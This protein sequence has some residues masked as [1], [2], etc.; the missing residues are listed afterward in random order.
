MLVFSNEEATAL[1]INYI[2]SNCTKNNNK[3][4]NI[5]LQ[6][7]SEKV[8]WSLVL[9]AVWCEDDST[10]YVKP[11]GEKVRLLYGDPVSTHAG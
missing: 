7:L 2:F 4:T 5:R 11:L 3:K 8:N 1:L 6:K 10:G 9:T